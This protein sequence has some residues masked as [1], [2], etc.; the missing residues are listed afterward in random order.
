MRV[1]VF[2]DVHG[3]RYALEAVLKDMEAHK[4]D[5]W[6]NLGDGLFGGADPA[7]A[8]TLQQEIKEKY[9]AKEIRGNTDERLGEVVRTATALGAPL[10][11]VSRA[12]LDRIA[13]TLIG[14][15]GLTLILRH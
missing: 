2:G 8:W 10:V 4:V 3:N 6:A 15:L 1:A 13:G 7:G 11:E 5:E 12:E 14:A 9:G